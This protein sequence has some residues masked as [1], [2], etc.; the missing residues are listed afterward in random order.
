[1]RAAYAVGSAATGGNLVATNLL[2]G[3]FIDALVNQLAV[4]SAGITMLPGL[5]GNVA[6]PKKST[7][8]QTYWVAESGAITEAEMTFAQVQLK[9]KVVGALSV[10]SRLA[11]QQ[12]TPD[13]EMVIRND[14]AGSLAREIDRVCLAGTG[15]N[16]QPLGVLNTSGIGSV[17]MG[18][19]GGAVT[20]EAMLDLRGAVAAANANASR[21]SFVINEKTA[22]AL[23]KLKSSGS[24]EFLFSPEGPMPGPGGIAVDRIAGNPVIISNQL[25]STGTKGTGT[26]LSTA[27]FGDWTD[28]ILGQWGAFEILVNPYESS[29]YSSGSVQVRAMQTVDVAVRNAASFAAV[30][31]LIA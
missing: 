16:N 22:T 25:V 4:A 13:I 30:T 3:S 20:L 23:R 8:T 21:G 28:L 29:V 2:A 12:T 11:L 19:N 14:L 18:T 7:T 26:G 27:V 17:A 15:T 5:V 9:P 24:G 31:D 10:Y 1:M 6:I